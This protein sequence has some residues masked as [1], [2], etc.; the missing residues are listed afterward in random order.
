MKFIRKIYLFSAL[1]G[2]GFLPM[3]VSAIA[4]SASDSPYVMDGVSNNKQSKKAVRVAYSNCTKWSKRC[5]KKKY[6]R[7]ST[8][9]CYC[10]RKY[11]GHGKYTV[12]KTCSIDR[13]RGY[14]TRGYSCRY[15]GKKYGGRHVYKT[16]KYCHKY[17]VKRSCYSRKRCY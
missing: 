3:T 13:M 4:S 6:Y 5:Y 11:R 10:C 15:I 17:C 1:V 16:R 12:K 9:Y 14:R 7:R 2:L 8:Y